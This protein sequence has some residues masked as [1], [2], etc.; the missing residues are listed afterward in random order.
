[1]LNQKR[2]FLNSGILYINHEGNS[3]MIIPLS[4]RKEFLRL[5]HDD[6]FSGHTGL[7]STMA[8]IERKVWWPSCHSGFK[9]MFKP[10]ISVKN[11]TEQQE[12]GMDICNLLVLLQDLGRLSIWTLLQVYH[13]LDN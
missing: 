7:K 9:N 13:L 11:Q 6:F 10:V 1:M 4:L 2:I 8:R 3:R 5:C 12:R